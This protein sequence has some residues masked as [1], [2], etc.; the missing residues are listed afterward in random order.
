MSVDSHVVVRDS[1][2]DPTVTHF[3]AVTISQYACISKHQV[4]HL[5]Y[6]PFVF[7]S[8]SSIELKKPHSYP[9]G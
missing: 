7:V 9:M 2:R 5:K 8:C 1:K 6:M 3:A 4:V